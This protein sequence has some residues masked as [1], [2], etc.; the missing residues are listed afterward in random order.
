MCVI[1]VGSPSKND[2][3]KDTFPNG[4]SFLGKINLISESPS[5]VAG[6]HLEKVVLITGPKINL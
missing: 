6:H 3:P 2:W 5:K 4:L 1:F